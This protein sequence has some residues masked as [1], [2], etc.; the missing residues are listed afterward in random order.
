MNMQ[1]RHNGQFAT[2]GKGAPA[3]TRAEIEGSIQRTFF[4]M[5]NLY[6]GDDVV[7]WS[8]PNEGK[9]G[10]V[11]TGRLKAMGLMPGAADVIAIWEAGGLLIEFK[12]PGKRQQPAQREFQKRVE[13][14]AWP[15]VV[16][17]SWIEAWQFL[18]AHGAPLAR[19]VREDPA[20]RF[21][22]HDEVHP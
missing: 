1:R 4:Q 21:I 12:A 15:Y 16:A 8:C 10:K 6:A 3:Q 18:E 14:V 19:L 11:Q 2:K 22:K 5:V 17:T 20:L 7:I 13:G 9:R